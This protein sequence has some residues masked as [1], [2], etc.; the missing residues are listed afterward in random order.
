MRL[1]PYRHYITKFDLVPD[2]KCRVRNKQAETGRAMNGQ[3]TAEVY[4]K[5]L[6]PEHPHVALM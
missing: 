4:E 5:A 2:K 1:E 6:G 3:Q